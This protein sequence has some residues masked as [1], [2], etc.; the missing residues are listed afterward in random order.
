MFKGLRTDNTSRHECKVAMWPVASWYWSITKKSPTMWQRLEEWTLFKY[1][2]KLLMKYCVES[3]A[4]FFKREIT[5]WMDGDE[6]R[7]GRGQD[8]GAGGLSG[9]L[10]QRSRKKF[11]FVSS[12]RKWERRESRERWMASE[13]LASITSSRVPTHIRQT[14]GRKITEF[15]G[16]NL[17]TGLT[18][19]PSNGPLMLNP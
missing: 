16:R 17:S 11:S 2:Q 5:L 10:C 18:R 7:K 14:V 15:C 6:V 1:V 3:A 13:K 4:T 19:C 8:T 12:E 9:P